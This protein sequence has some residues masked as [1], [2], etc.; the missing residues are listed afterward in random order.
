MAEKKAPAPQYALY[1]DTILPW[2]R[3]HYGLLMTDYFDGGTTLVAAL[4][5]DT[6]DETIGRYRCVASAAKYLADIQPTTRS[7]A[8]QEGTAQRQVLFIGALVLYENGPIPGTALNGYDNP[9]VTMIWIARKGKRFEGMG[10]LR[11][12]LFDKARSEESRLKEIINSY[13]AREQARRDAE[14][15]SHNDIF[16]RGQ[17][18]GETRALGFGV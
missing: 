10:G 7:V 18:A 12:L 3:P 14:S 16:L 11:E 9:L 6:L 4:G 5:V 2:K 1:D 13:I 15:K 8:E 17:E